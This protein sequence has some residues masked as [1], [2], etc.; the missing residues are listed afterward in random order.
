MKRNI[1]TTISLPISHSILEPKLESLESK[2]KSE[3]TPA[4]EPFVDNQPITIQIEFAP[5][6]PTIILG[7]KPVANAKR[8][9]VTQKSII[10]YSKRSKPVSQDY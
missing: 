4:L 5:E 2:P 7:P 8:G 9:K 1:G 10:V 6:L 3:P